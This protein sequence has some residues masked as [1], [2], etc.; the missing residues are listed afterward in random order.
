MGR[1]LQIKN[2]IGFILSFFISLCCAT[3][4]WAYANYSLMATSNDSARVARFSVLTTIREK[5]IVLNG[6]EEKTILFTVANWD[7]AASEVSIVYDVAVSLPVKLESLDG[8]KIE[9]FRNGEQKTEF[10]K[11]QSDYEVVY[12]FYDVGNFEA[13]IKAT[14]RCELRVSI[15]APKLSETFKLNI[16]AVARQ[17]C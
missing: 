16:D 4:G 14:D 8:F 7:E 17:T 10:T 13:G 9:L 3:I 11:E 15:S 2:K 12:L 1:S 5:H 6:D